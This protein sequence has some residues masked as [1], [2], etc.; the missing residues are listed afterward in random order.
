MDS[1]ASF[2]CPLSYQKPNPKKV[3]PVAP[4]RAHEKYQQT[5][6]FDSFAQLTY[7]RGPSVNV[8]LLLNQ[9][10]PK[11]LPAALCAN[12]SRATIK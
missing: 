11:S 1:I 3:A 12:F 6:L 4:A 5:V 8:S 10:R 9:N 7:L 2:P